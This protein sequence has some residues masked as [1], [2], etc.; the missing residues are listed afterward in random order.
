MTLDSSLAFENALD[1]IQ[2]LTVK[3]QCAIGTVK[4]LTA[5]LTACELRRVIERAAFIAGELTEAPARE[6]A[7]RRLADLRAVADR[8]LALAPTPSPSAIRQARSSDWKADR[9]DWER[10]E[11]QWIAA[12]K[13]SRAPSSSESL[14]RRTLPA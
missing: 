6:D 1:A 2:D 5:W 8:V 7:M 14:S 3:L 12:R 11:Q 13:A 10:E 4:Y 9:S